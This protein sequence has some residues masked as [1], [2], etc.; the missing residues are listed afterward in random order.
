MAWHDLAE[1]QAVEL[2]HIGALQ[3]IEV[4]YQFEQ[5]C[6]FTATIPSG[7]LVLAYLVEELE[8][9]E[10]FRYLLATTAAKTVEDLKTGAISVREALLRGSLWL[11]D[12]GIDDLVPKQVF[13]LSADQ[14]PTDALPE[15]GTML[16]PSLEPVLRV[17]L[18]GEQIKFGALPAPVLAHAAEIAKTALKPIYEWL[19]RRPRAD[20]QGRPPE[21]LR[22]LYSLQI[23]HLS[24]GS[25]EVGL[26]LPGSVDT[27][28]TDLLAK[29]DG[30]NDV[31]DIRAQGWELLRQGLDWATSDNQDDRDLGEAAPAILDSLRRLAPTSSSKGPVTAVEVSG[32]MLGHYA[33]T[34]SLT[35]QTTARIRTILTQTGKTQE[36]FLRV[37]EGRIRSLDLDLLRFILRNPYT[38][39]DEVQFL[40]D[41]ERFLED[42]KEAYYQELPVKIAGRSLDEK[43]WTVVDL[44]FAAVR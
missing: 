42:A 25:L 37:F 36:T 24:P 35:Q 23:Q 11:A 15:P 20:L 13:S 16:L 6:I 1:L 39:V 43:S 3:P 10:R 14:L 44:E 22:D 40:L 2:V 28:S 21:W 19:A 29:V 4:L 31:Q 32:A 34:Y 30:V 33:K 26:R 8:Q 7:S 9:D 17:R 12:L 5:P 41:D 38:G 27:D 18:H